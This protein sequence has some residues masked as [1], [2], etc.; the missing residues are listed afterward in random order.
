MGNNIERQTAEAILGYG[1][2]YRVPAPRW[3]RLFGV[4]RVS[5]TVR[6]LKL[7][8]E[9]EMARVSI[10]ETR[11]ATSLQ[12]DDFDEMQYFID[13][14]EAFLRI[15]AIATLNDK[16]KI[17][18]MTRWRMRSLRRLPLLHLYELWLSVRRMSGV[19][20]FSTII[21]LMAETMTTRPNLSQTA[22][23]S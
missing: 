21:R 11:H 20:D 4:K 1:K 14:A 19:K 7:G 12:S 6:P 5:V 3:L 16:W 2:R 17:R 22:E 8:T 23:G 9:L 13:N 15:V 18:F 10:V